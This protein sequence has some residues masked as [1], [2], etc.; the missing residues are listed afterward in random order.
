MLFIWSNPSTPQKTTKTTYKT[1]DL[2]GYDTN[3]LYKTYGGGSS[4]GGGGGYSVA[5][6]DISGLLDAY[7]QQAESARQ[8]AETK[9]TNTRNDLL[10]SLKRFQE[11]N[12]SDLARYRDQNALELNRYREQNAADTL[13]QKQNY[14]ANQA[15]LESAREQANRQNRIS[16][17]ARG[18]GGS[19][20]QQLAQLQN[21]LGQS[22]E[23]S[24]AAGS[25]QTAMDKLATLLREYEEDS[26]TRLRNYEA[27]MAKQL[28]EYQEDSDTKLRQNEEERANTLNSI[29]SALANQRAAA[30]V[31][32]E[33]AYT[34]ALN[35][36]RAQAAAS[37]ASASSNNNAARQAANKVLGV[38]SNLT[39]KLN[40]EL[41]EVANMSN[42]QRKKL[43]GTSDVSK[44]KSQ[45]KNDYM[46]ELSTL[47]A[48]YG[49]G[50][51][52]S[53]TAQNNINTLLKGLTTTTYTTGVTPT[54]KGNEYY[55]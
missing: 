39:T 6:A 50:S 23:I 16:A 1:S 3:S 31:Q 14:L 15:S 51:D 35:Q 29:A 28:S 4:S 47:Q 13:N 54:K 19:G 45:I 38:V 26:S 21:L 34:N 9:Y 2:A 7:N 48:D 49:F 11:Q 22:E 25:N 40:K 36:A 18:L 37:R 27:D 8:V 10:T 43:Y 12:A 33:Q 44:I 30:I 53:K 55:F 41:T 52:I 24:R 46:S 32:N 5:K 20:L 17:S 42:S